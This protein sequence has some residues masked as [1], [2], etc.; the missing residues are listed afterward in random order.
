MCEVNQTT[1]IR[2]ARKYCHYT[3]N[4]AKREK[5]KLVELEKKFAKAQLPISE[6]ISQH[7]SE[8]LDTQ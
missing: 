7:V 3:D 8:E 1:L 6:E 4:V 5:R 2:W